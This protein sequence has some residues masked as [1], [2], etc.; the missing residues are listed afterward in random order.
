M[1]YNYVHNSISY[2]MEN[3]MEGTVD[4]ILWCRMEYTGNNGYSIEYI[5]QL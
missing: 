1:L 3:I 4:Y 5:Y 2:N